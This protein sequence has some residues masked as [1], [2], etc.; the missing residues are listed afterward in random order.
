MNESELMLG[1]A[2]RLADAAVQSSLDETAERLLDELHDDPAQPKSTFR[3]IPLSLYGGGLPNE[4]RSSWVFALRRGM[5]HPPERHPNSIQRMFALNQPGCF[6]YWDGNTWITR[7]LFPR[8]AGLSI[9]IDTW[10]RMPAQDRDWAVASFHTAA[11]DELVE[12]VGDPQSGEISTERKYVTGS[13][14]I[15]T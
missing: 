12:I 10:H 15:E 5:A 4:I 9:P 1:L 8:D 6:E 14:A 2:A 3:P 13:G 11:A 7:E